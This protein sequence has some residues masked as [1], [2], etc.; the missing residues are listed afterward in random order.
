VTDDRTG[1]SQILAAAH[2]PVT[3]NE[4]GAY[5]VAGF[6]VAAG[7]NGEVRVA[8]ATP[9]PD[10][11]DPERPSDDEVADA[12][13]RMVN[14]YARTLEAAGYKVKRRGQAS[15]KPYLLASR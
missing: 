8:H 12:R 7:S 2:R 9:E 14:A 4:Y 5:I 6:S 10:L 13:H 15:R 1:A 11:L 3:E